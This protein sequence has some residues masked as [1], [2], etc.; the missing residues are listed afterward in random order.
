M[1]YL[2][3]V[4]ST[5]EWIDFASELLEKHNKYFLVTDNRC[6]DH[7]QMTIEFYDSKG[8]TNSE[9]IY[10]GSV[11]IYSGNFLTTE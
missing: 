6:V 1:Y 10:Y 2:G 9:H 7:K 4:L 3:D 8:L 11:C 5:I